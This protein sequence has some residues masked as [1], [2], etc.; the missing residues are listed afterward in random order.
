MNIAKNHLRSTAVLSAMTLLAP[1]GAFAAGNDGS[2]SAPWFN[3]EVNASRLDS[4]TT[5]NPVFCVLDSAGISRFTFGNTSTSVTV[6]DNSQSGDLKILNGSFFLAY[7][8]GF[9]TTSTATD[10][11]I[12]VSGSESFLSCEGTLEIGLYGLNNTLELGGGADLQA[13]EIFLGNGLSTDPSMGCGNRIVLSGSGTTARAYSQLIVGYNGCD[14]SISITTGATMDAMS[15]AIGVGAS[16]NAALGVGNSALVSG[17]GSILRAYDT[18][19][20]LGSISSD[21]VLTVANG[22]SVIAKTTLAI[23]LQ[24]G[25]DDNSMT[26]TGTGSSISAESG[27]YVGVRGNRNSLYLADGAALNTGTLNIGYTGNASNNNLFVVGEKTEAFIAAGVQIGASGSATTQN[28]HLTI[29]DGALVK[30]GNGTYAPVLNIHGSNSIRFAGGFLAIQGN[31]TA[32]L[33][34][35]V[36]TN[37]IEVWNAFSAT[38]ATGILDTGSVRTLTIQYFSGATAEADAKA[39]TGHD[40]LAGYTVM[41]APNTQ[42]LYGWADATSAW[43][44]WYESPWLGTFYADCDSYVRW[45][46]HAEHGWLWLYFPS[47]HEAI[48]WDDATGSWWYIEKDWYP[49]MYSY[50]AQS[51]FYYMDG[52]VPSR[53]FWSY[54][55]NAEVSESVLH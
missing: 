42:A 6:W 46:W 13:L 37:R 44:G 48:A 49:A 41:Y 11:R 39:L 35:L 30:V 12:T 24:A 14:N 3:S 23:G 29:S 18:G 43:R 31:Q 28:N 16:S 4:S 50:D 47:D 25:S 17:S 38:W 45:I 9:A 32:A 55:A 5:A 1:L 10:N 7:N 15:I 53:S 21:N 19:I 40:G 8:L 22:G 34:S 2:S 36:D 27:A 54:G 33:T 52:S 20:S 26:V 51:W